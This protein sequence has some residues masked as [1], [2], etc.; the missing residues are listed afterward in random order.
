MRMSGRDELRLKLNNKP[1]YWISRSTPIKSESFK[2][3]F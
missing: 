2:Q 1:S 3:Q